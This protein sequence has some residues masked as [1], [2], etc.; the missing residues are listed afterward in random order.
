[1][2]AT[3]KI[4]ALAL[5][6]NL[7]PEKHFSKAYEKLRLMGDAVFSNIYLIPC[8]DG[9]GADYWNSACL[10]KST[11]T[12]QEMLDSVKALET[13]MGRVRPSHKISL[14]IDVIAWGDDLNQM[15]F[16]QKKLPLAVD[17]K[18]P[19]FELWQSDTLKTSHIR[20]PKVTFTQAV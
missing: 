10:L 6:S 17:V 19:L 16:N 15:H 13:E 9:V 18:I 4:F 3:E 11:K 1:M 20:Y 12:V 5:A 14:D 7:S 2:N 8:R